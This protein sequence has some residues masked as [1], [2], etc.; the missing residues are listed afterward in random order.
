[1]MELSACFRKVFGTHKRTCVLQSRLLL[2]SNYHC[3]EK[4]VTYHLKS[5]R[6]CIKAADLYYFLF[7]AAVGPGGGRDT[8]VSRP[9]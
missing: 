3:N 9:L 4:L 8:F 5:F 6:A 2:V 1:M 7:C